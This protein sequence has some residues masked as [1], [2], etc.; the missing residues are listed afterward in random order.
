MVNYISECTKVSFKHLQW[1]QSLNICTTYNGKKL[2]LFQTRNSTRKKF[3]ILQHSYHCARWYNYKVMRLYYK[4]V[5][6]QVLICVWLCNPRDCSL[7]GSSVH[8][9]IQARILEW[10]AI[11]YSRGSSRSRDWTHLSCISWTGWWI[12]YQLHHLGN[13]IPNTTPKSSYV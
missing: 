6:A 7:P 1:W 8:G 13:Y 3:K 4:G 2:A 10:V 11:S 5:Q 12:L 9:T